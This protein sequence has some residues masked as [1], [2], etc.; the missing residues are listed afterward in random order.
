MQLTYPEKFHIDL[1]KRVLNHALSNPSQHDQDFEYEICAQVGCV[2]G[3]GGG[4]LWV[5]WMA[6]PSPKGI[7]PS[8]Y[9]EWSDIFNVRC[10]TTRTPIE[11]LKGHYIAQAENVQTN[12]ELVSR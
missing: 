5:N 9:E 4:L 10:T 1:A 3:L 7:W 11:K 12:A 2:Y 8:T 6:I